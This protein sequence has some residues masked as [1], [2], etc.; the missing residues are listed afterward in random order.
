MYQSYGP[1]KQDKIIKIATI[2]FANN[3]NDSEISFVNISR[4]KK[5]NADIH[6]YYGIEEK[7]N[8]RVSQL[9]RLESPLEITKIEK[10]ANLF[11]LTEII[12]YIRNRLTQVRTYQDVSKNTIGPYTNYVVNL[13]SALIIDATVDWTSLSISHNAHKIFSTTKTFDS[14]NVI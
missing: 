8:R 4:A 11:H 6:Y 1:R 2:I 7:E 12:T 5:W 9:L 10:N 14:L 13:V 3:L